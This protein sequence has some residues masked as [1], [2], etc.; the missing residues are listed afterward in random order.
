MSDSLGVASRAG[1]KGRPERPFR[2]VF[3]LRDANSA[4]SCSRRKT[5]SSLAGVDRGMDDNA[6][7]RRPMIPFANVQKR[8]DGETLIVRDLNLLAPLIVITLSYACA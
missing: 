8:Y 6:S 7:S 4:P 3:Q 2:G 5:L 1:P